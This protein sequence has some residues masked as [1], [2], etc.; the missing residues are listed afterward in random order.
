M[1][2]IDRPRCIC[3]PYR[4]K[5]RTPRQTKY[6]KRIRLGTRITHDKESEDRSSQ[7]QT[8]D[9]LG[10]GLSAPPDDP[11]DDQPLGS[12]QVHFHQQVTS[13][14]PMTVP[15]PDNLFQ[16]AAVTQ[17]SSEVS[18]TSYISRHHLTRQT[19]EDLLRLL[20]AYASTKL[21]ICSFNCTLLMVS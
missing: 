17:V 5:K 3:G 2:D 21:L 1:E 13:T 19:Q 16:D 15:Q 9:N 18:I 14:R 20:Q 6:E 10:V 11:G 4:L 8:P 7:P 12:C